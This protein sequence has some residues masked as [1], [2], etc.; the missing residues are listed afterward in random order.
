MAKTQKMKNK[1]KFFN[2]A[3]NKEGTAQ[4]LLTE[5]AVF[6]NITQAEAL[7]QI[8]HEMIEIGVYNE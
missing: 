5:Y 8:Y 2:W 6:Q 3:Y 7:A 4:V 1:I